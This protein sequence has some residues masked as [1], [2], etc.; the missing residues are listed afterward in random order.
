VEERDTLNKIRKEKYISLNEDKRKK[1]WEQRKQ[2]KKDRKNRFF[3]S[4]GIKPAD[5]GEGDLTADRK[6]KTAAEAD[7]KVIREIGIKEAA[8]ILADY[9]TA[10][11]P[12]AAMASPV[13]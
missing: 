8:R 3:N 1:R 12:R 2:A 13:Q 11:S 4:I 9:I 7:L 5:D 6:R 10:S